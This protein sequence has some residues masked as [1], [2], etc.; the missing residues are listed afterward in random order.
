MPSER[1]ILCVVCGED[2]DASLPGWTRADDAWTC[3]ACNAA[4]MDGAQEYGRGSDGYEHSSANMTPWQA[5]GD[6]RGKN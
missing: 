3:P 6:H 4:V 5:W 1:T 2:S